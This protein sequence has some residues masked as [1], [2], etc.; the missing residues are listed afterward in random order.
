MGL[1]WLPVTRSWLE[2]HLKKQK[3]N[4][5][6]E[7]ADVNGF[8]IPQTNEENYGELEKLKLILWGTEMPIHQ[9][10]A[11]TAQESTEQDDTDR[12]RADLGAS[13][14]FYRFTESLVSIDKLCS[15]K[16]CSPSHNIHSRCRK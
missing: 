15:L 13:S 5:N 8:C 7:Q 14:T 4:N 11:P 3:S 2:G 16:L 6:H 12:V 9:M 1:S 10:I